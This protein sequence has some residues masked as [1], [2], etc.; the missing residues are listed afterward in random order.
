MYVHWAD[1]HSLVSITMKELYYSCCLGTDYQLVL[2]VLSLLTKPSSLTEFCLN[3]VAV[4]AAETAPL[5][6]FPGYW[7]PAESRGS[8]KLWLVHSWPWICTPGNLRFQ[9][10]QVK[11]G[12]G[13]LLSWAYTASFSP[14]NLTLHFNS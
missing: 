7:L 2:A 13:L 3:C 4:L 8:C 1:D 12:S 11:E 10:V 6:E 5:L 14:A 9:K